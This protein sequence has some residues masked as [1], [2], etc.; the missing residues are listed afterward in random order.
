MRGGSEFGGTE[1]FEL[2]RQLGAG[3]M[4]VVYQAYDR[5]RDGLVALKT[6]SQVDAGSLYRFKREFRAL[7][8]LAHP[9]LATLHELF[10]KDDQWFFTMEL[11]EG[12][13]FVEYARAPSDGR[14]REA[15][16]VKSLRQLVDG[17]GALHAAGHLH[18]DIKPSNVLVTEQGRVV[19]L[20]F[21]L[22]TP[23]AGF[24]GYHSTTPRVLGTLAYMAP[25]QGSGRPLSEASD[26]YSV[27]LMLYEA[28]TGRI[29]FVEPELP[30]DT[31]SAQ[32][33]A[34]PRTLSDSQAD[35][36]E[37]ATP[38]VPGPQ[39]NWIR[40][41][42]ARL[43][44]EPPP[45][46]Q[47]EPEVPA[48][49]NDICVGLLRSQP[50]AR[51]SRPQILER[52]GAVEPGAVSLEAVP[53]VPF[54]CRADHLQALQEAFETVRRGRPVTVYVHGSSGIGK[55]ALARRFLDG[56]L[57]RDR[58]VVLEGRCYEQES[59]PYK[60]LD[61]IVDALSHYLACLK[62]ALAAELLPRDTWALARAFP[63]LS[64]VDLIAEWPSDRS[65]R[66][67]RWRCGGAPSRPCASCWRAPA[68]AGRW[69][70]SWTT[71]SG[72]TWTAPCCSR[73]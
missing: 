44:S 72:A 6:M 16:L 62:R 24:G 64:R 10:F 42:S 1:R 12:R 18:R 41:L 25:E 47:L 4:G 38:P 28:L 34:L 66:P 49:L 22:V 60:A 69:C 33:S 40:V 31:R 35:T 23:L 57:E 71:C 45:P 9:N 65:S 50:E 61:S 32:R 63:V 56:L 67:T 15:R 11:V 55:T 58:A 48:A 70:C 51:L 59:V 39:V 7:A 68:T 43:D 52:L 73:S 37:Q 30:G 3:G 20:D 2:R 14:E 17:V 26:W 13:N 36:Q 8:D 54:V 46:R 27:G 5:E 19:L 53:A 29:P 21:G